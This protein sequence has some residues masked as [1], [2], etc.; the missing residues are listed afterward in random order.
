MMNKV[1]VVRIN[2]SFK[3]SGFRTYAHINRLTARRAGCRRYDA[4][5]LVILVSG[6]T[7]LR[8]KG[9]ISGDGNIN[10]IIPSGKRIMI[11][12]IIF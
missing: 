2:R 3:L 7:V 6:R 5:K 9:N 4:Y 1:M 8:G 12:V 10:V 11:I